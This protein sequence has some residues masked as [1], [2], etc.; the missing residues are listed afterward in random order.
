LWFLIALI[1][2]HVRNLDHLD[3]VTAL[4]NPKI[5]D[6]I[7][8]TLPEGWPESLNTPKIIVT[9]RKALYGIKQAPQLWH[10]D[11]DAFLLTLEC[12]QSTA[13]P[14]I[15]LPS[16]VVLILLY[17]NNISM[18]YPEGAAKAAMPVEAKL[19]EIYKVTNLRLPRQYLGIGIYPK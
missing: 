9:L 12:T 18:S 19:S 13:N 8:M 6:D 7:Y 5:D 15:N 17:V 14:Y 3:E 4:L 2:R 11:N 16:D 10:D 1:P